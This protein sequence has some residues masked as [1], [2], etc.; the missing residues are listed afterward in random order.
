MYGQTVDV[1]DHSRQTY[2][3]MTTIPTAPG[4]IPFV[5]PPPPPP[6]PPPLHPPGQTSHPVMSNTC[7]RLELRKLM[8]INKMLSQDI[9]KLVPRLHL[10]MPLRA[11]LF[12]SY[13]SAGSPWSL[14]VSGITRYFHVTLKITKSSTNL[15]SSPV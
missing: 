6:P 1:L 14:L 9:H 3:T 13:H 4:A 2:I 15:L 12:V 10:H 5:P 11:G 8:L 7:N